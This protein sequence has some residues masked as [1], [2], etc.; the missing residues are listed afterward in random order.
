[1]DTVTFIRL[2]SYSIFNL[3]NTKEL[4][5]LMYSTLMLIVGCTYSAALCLHVLICLQHYVISVYFY[6]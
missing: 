1:M 6:F 5:L 2:F 3:A 4:L